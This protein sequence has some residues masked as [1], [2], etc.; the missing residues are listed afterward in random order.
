M[1]KRTVLDAFGR[2]GKPNT[3]GLDVLRKCFYCGKYSG[4]HDHNCI[5]KDVKASE[6]DVDTGKVF[7]PYGPTR[8][9]R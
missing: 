9:W 5:A 3:L 6:L 4:A 7:L 8:L 1:N 2:T